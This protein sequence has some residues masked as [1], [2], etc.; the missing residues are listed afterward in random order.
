MF[1][2]LGV[3]VAFYVLYAALS[4][5]VFAKSGVFGRTIARQDS[6]IHFWVVVF[7]YLGISIALITFF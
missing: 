5:K 1:K 4:G 3:L 6:P 7:I 2:A